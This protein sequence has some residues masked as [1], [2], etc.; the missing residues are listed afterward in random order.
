MQYYSYDKSYKLVRDADSNAANAQIFNDNVQWEM[1]EE[2][3]VS[4]MVMNTMI[5]NLQAWND[6]HTVAI[7]DADPETF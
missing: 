4:K 5:D 6:A 2:T 1:M 7:R 3:L